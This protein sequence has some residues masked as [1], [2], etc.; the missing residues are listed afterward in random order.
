[1]EKTFKCNH[2]SESFEKREDYKKHCKISEHEY[3]SKCK[4][5]GKDFYEM[6]ESTAAHQTNCNLNPRKKEIK[7]KIRLKAIGRPLSEAH[8]KKVSES[9]I[10]YLK[11]HP[12]KVPYLLNHSSRRS[13]PEIVVENEFL[14]RGIK[15]WV[16][17][18][19][20]GIYEYDFAFPE[21]KVDI[22]IDGYQHKQEKYKESDKRRD[23]W[24]ISQGWRVLRIEASIIKN[25]LLLAVNE[26][27]KFIGKENLETQKILS[28]SEYGVLSNEERYLKKESKREKRRKK[29]EEFKKAE[30]FIKENFL[31]DTIDKRLLKTVAKEI[32]IKS[33]LLNR[34]SRKLGKTLFKTRKK[35]L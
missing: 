34:A 24:S 3:S 35:K 4:F 9:R 32:G 10:K 8:R 16:S 2:C 1:M 25:S 21:L 12:D 33:S 15:G 23:E 13:N 26:I 31:S 17:K 30:D 5:C 22:E 11:E 19:R 27:E 20:N 18:F 29:L 14:K 6:Y 7:E 28:P